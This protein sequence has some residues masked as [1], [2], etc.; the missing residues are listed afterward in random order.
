MLV[1]RDNAMMATL[2][3]AQADAC[4]FDLV[5]A[6]L[7]R[8]PRSELAALEQGEMA[9]G[10][11]KP[12][13]CPKLA[14][15]VSPLSEVLTHL[16]LSNPQSPSPSETRGVTMGYARNLTSSSVISTSAFPS[17]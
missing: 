7:R 2:I 14:L 9:S 15:N 1:E 4:R 8:P 16:S 11:G 17:S 13:Q 3:F 12:R 10:T 5:H 6:H